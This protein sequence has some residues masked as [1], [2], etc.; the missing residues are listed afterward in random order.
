MTTID[1][2]NGRANGQ[3]NNRV[4]SDKLVVRRQPMETPAEDLPPLSADDQGA[5]ARFQMR[6]QGLRELTNG[7]ID[8][9][10]TGFCIHG[11]PG[12]GKT[13]TVEDTLRARSADWKR[14]Q[15]ITAK[16]LFLALQ[17]HP[18]AVHVV[19]DCEQLLSE[20]SALTLLRSALGGERVNGRRERQ[21]FYSV[22]GAHAREMQFYFHGAIILLGN[23][24]LAAEKEE[25]RAIISRVPCHSYVPP[26]C[27]IRAFMRSLARKGFVGEN[28]R[29]SPSECIEVVEY[30]IKQVAELQGQLD[31]RWI[32]H[33]YG[34]YLTAERGGKIDWR[35]MIKNHVTNTLTSCDFTGHKVKSGND[36]SRD[37]RASET[38]IA[39]EISQMP[40]LTRAERLALWEERTRLSRATYYRRLI[41]G[42]N[43]PAVE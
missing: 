23:R 30:V 38:A 25:V 27:E 35:D 33:A 24:P 42:S 21:V 6:Q 2:I 26:D 41:A 12:T 7:C 10:H 29:M 11:A 19:D 36:K 9:D 1:V 39:W 15:R 43:V 37:D 3:E 17:Q 31:L 8:G 40:D 18:G 22:A 28:G 20:K 14:H 32:E 13:F 16:P 4:N 5:L 34:H